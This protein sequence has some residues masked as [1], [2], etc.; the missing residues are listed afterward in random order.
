M[1]VAP[2]RTKHSAGTQMHRREFITLVGAA[3]VMGPHAARAQKAPVVIG[4]LGSQAAAPPPK[5][6]QTVALNQ[7]FLDHGLIQGRDFIFEQLRA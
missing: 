4:F 3:A 7:G 1:L 5:D 2:Y 6:P